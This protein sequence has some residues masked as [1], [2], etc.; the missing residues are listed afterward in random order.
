[1]PEEQLRAARAELRLL[2]FPGAR[3][4]QKA[5]HGAG[6]GAGAGGAAGAGDGGAAGAAEAAGGGALAG[7]LRGRALRAAADEVASE[8]RPTTPGKD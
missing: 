3:M 7:A 8:E 1:M 2:V 6:A 4:L 5:L